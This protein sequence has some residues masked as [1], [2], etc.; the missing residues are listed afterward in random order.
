MFAL[1]LMPHEGIVI[2][3]SKSSRVNTAIHMLFMNFDLAVIWLN[4]EKI[5]VDKVLA[6]KWAP[7]YVPKRAAQYVLELHPS[8]FADFSPG[9]QCA[10]SEG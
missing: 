5:V 1:E 10:F 9:D 6:K 2:A 7:I 4:E 3:E 8:R